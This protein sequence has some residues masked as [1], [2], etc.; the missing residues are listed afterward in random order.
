[1]KTAGYGALREICAAKSNNYR[2]GAVKRDLE[3]LCSDHAC[4]R[5]Q[6]LFR[7]TEQ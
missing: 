7:E 1:M 2:T 4:L 5:Q 3:P 6:R